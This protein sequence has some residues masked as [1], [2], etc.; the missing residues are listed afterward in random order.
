MTRGAFKALLLAQG[1]PPKVLPR[2]QHPDL[3]ASAYTKKIQALMKRVHAMTLARLVPLLKKHTEEASRIATTDANETEQELIARVR[4]QEKE[5]RDKINASK[6]FRLAP[7]TLT[8]EEIKLLPEEKQKKA[9]RSASP[10][11]LKAIQE[12]ELTPEQREA[13]SRET[14]RNRGNAKAGQFGYSFDTLCARETCGHTNGVHTAGG[15]WCHECDCDE[16]IG[17]SASKSEAAE[18]RQIGATLDALRADVAKLFEREKLGAMVEP[19]AGLT[20]KFQAEQL[21]RQLREAV[22][23]DVVGSEPWIAKAATEF[24]REN[25]A[26]IRTIPSRYFDEIETLVMREA[27]DGVRWEEL[28]D[29]IEERYDVSRSRSKIIA[30]DQIGKFY[31]DL[32]RVRQ[33]DL[34]ITRFVWR[35]VRDN[36]VRPEHADIDGE[37]FAWGSAPDGGPGEAVL[38]RCYAEPDLSSVTDEVA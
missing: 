16:F 4:A 26:L 12:G 25:V 13:N 20:E 24:T 19:F 5:Q 36:R 23:L 34:G 6:K 28:V 3:I 22:A 9:L 11:T 21:N 7:E 38:C 33:T 10:E 18:E 1:K 15:G 8:A 14:R 37:S 31:G 30:R 35:T 27:A 29:G 2:Q 17:P 32:N